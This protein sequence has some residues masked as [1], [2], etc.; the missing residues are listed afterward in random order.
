MAVSGDGGEST[1]PN[2][3]WIERPCFNNFHCETISCSVIFVSKYDAQIAQ[4]GRPKQKYG[5]HQHVVVLHDYSAGRRPWCR[6]PSGHLPCNYSRLSL[7]S[8]PRKIIPLFSLKWQTNSAF[9]HYGQ[10]FRIPG[11]MR[12]ELNGRL[13]LFCH[14]VRNSRKILPAFTQLLCHRFY[15]YTSALLSPLYQTPY[16]PLS[17]LDPVALVCPT[18]RWHYLWR[19]YYENILG[20]IVFSNPVSLKH[21]TRIFPLMTAKLSQM[22]KFSQSSHTSKIDQIPLSNIFSAS[23]SSAL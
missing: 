5:G 8:L 4:N 17:P 9:V 6:V 18:N 15:Y 14:F 20:D 12:V 2:T 22:G 10:R 19:Q 21:L 11:S 16:R 23:T 1:K 13:L 7:Y 3:N